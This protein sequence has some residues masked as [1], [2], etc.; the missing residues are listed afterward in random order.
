MKKKER[1][2]FGVDGDIRFIRME[3]ENLNSMTFSGILLLPFGKSRNRDLWES[4]IKR[5][6][7]YKEDHLNVL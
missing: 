7:T 2:N 5:V 1:N 6:K 3:K 4:K